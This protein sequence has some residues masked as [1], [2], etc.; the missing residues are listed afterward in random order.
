MNVLFDLNGVIEL[1]RG[2][3]IRLLSFIDE[4]GPE[5]CAILTSMSGFT[6]SMLEEDDR[7]EGRFRQIVSAQVVGLDKRDPALYR[8]VLESL[9]WTVDETVF[10]DDLEGN[11]DAAREAG[12]TTIR[13]DG[14][15]EALIERLRLLA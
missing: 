14:D 3:N 11:V 5:R 2:M 15:T 7:F 10:V 6:V 1:P 8:R 4:L 12:L 9:R 13:F